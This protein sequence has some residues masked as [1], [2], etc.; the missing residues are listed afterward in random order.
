[1]IDI[2]ANNFSFQ[3]ATFALVFT[4]IIAMLC[5]DLIIGSN[6]IF[7]K[8]RLML[9][10]VLTI[11]VT[12]FIPITAIDIFSLQ[13]VTAI[14]Q[15]V[16]TGVVIA[17]IF[18][19]VFQVTIFSGQLIASQSGLAFATLTDP[20]SNNPINILSEF[21]FFAAILLFLSLNGHLMVIKLMIDSFVTMPL[22][23][24]LYLQNLPEIVN[25]SAV[26]FSGG[27]TIAL[28]CVTA[29]LI[30]NIA[31][32]FM[33]RSATPLS[34]F[35]VG[36]PLTIIVGLA[37]VFFSFSGAMESMRTIFQEGFDAIHSII[38]VN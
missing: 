32:G 27:L 30:V 20:N 12:P 28:P 35:N 2:S 11:L 24:T 21:Y 7:F 1:M 8:F 16:L 4:R 25:F 38:M 26:I 31:F 29:L 18:Q 14:F 33:A 9:A 15:Q 6:M 34:L 3:L 22:T 19:F 5:T 37:M 13:G 17:A 10:V 36:L 23:S